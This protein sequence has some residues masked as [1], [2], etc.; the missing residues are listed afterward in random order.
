VSNSAPADI[1]PDAAHLD[2]VAAGV[3]G[4]VQPD[5]T[6]WINNCGV[7]A[8]PDRTVLIDTCGTERRTRHLLETVQAR[9]GTRVSTLVD[10][11]HHGDHTH[12]NYLVDES[13]IV[14][15]E[16]CRE[17]IVGHGITKY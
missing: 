6:W 15:H 14:G 9:T 8:G 17:L 7:I 1:S 2:E 13:V 5:G 10:T 11:H 3:F 4:Y 16:L 12:G